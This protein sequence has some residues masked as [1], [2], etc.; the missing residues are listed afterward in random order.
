M[1]SLL[2]LFVALLAAQSAQSAEEPSFLLQKFGSIDGLL[3]DERDSRDVVRCPAGLDFA[4]DRLT[5]RDGIGFQ[6]VWDSLLEWRVYTL[7]SGTKCFVL[8]KPKLQILDPTD[9][10]L[11]YAVRRAYLVPPDPHLDTRFQAPTLSRPMER[12]QSPE[13]RA[14]RFPKAERSPKTIIDIRQDDRE[15]VSP[16]VARNALAYIYIPGST[17]TSPGLSAGTGTQITPYAWLTNAHVIRPGNAFQTSALLYATY[18]QTLPLFVSSKVPVH[19]MSVARDYAGTPSWHDI[20]AV[21][22]TEPY[23]RERYLAILDSFE[24]PS[25]SSLGALVG[26]PAHVRNQPNSP[27]RP[28]TDLAN[29]YRRA[30]PEFLPNGPYRY[31]F[32]RGK[33]SQGQSGGPAH[34]DSGAEDKLW[35]LVTSS[36]DGLIPASAQD[37]FLTEIVYVTPLQYQN[38]AFVRAVLE[39]HPPVSILT[40]GLYNGVALDFN[41]FD[42]FRA[43]AGNGTK[44]LVWSSSLDGVFGQGGYV[45]SAGT[46]RTGIHE[47]TIA[48]DA[49]PGRL[50]ATSD[51]T[52]GIGN[53]RRLRVEVLG[54][55]GE[56]RQS[57]GSGEYAVD[58]RNNLASVG[59]TWTSQNG[60]ASAVVLNEITGMHVGSGPQGFASTTAAPGTHKFGFF[61]DQTRIVLI[62]RESMSVFV[63][64][65]TLSA[66]PSVCEIVPTRLNPGPSSCDTVI[67]WT[68]GQF[69][70]GAPQAPDATVY[71]RRGPAGAWAESF[72]APSS[73][74]SSRAIELG[75]T[76]FALKQFRDP[77][78]GNLA[79]PIVAKAVRFADAREYNNEPLYAPALA[80]VDGALQESLNFSAPGDIDWLEVY[81][82]QAGR[83]YRFATS[84]DA[85]VR[86]ELAVYGYIDTVEDQ[87]GQ[88]P[89][90]VRNVYLIGSS[91]AAANGSPLSIDVTVPSS[92]SYAGFVVR[93]ANQNGA[94]CARA[95]AQ[96]TTCSGFGYL[97]SAYDLTAAAQADSYEPDGTR[98]SARPIDGGGASQTHTFHTASDEDWVMFWLPAGYRATVDLRPNNTA[99]GDHWNAEFWSVVPGTSNLAHLTTRSFGGAGTQLVGDALGG[100]MFWIRVRSPAG[101]VQGLDSRYVV[102]VAAELVAQQDAYEPDDTRETAVSNGPSSTTHNFHTS[103]D[104][105]WTSMWIGAGWRARIAVAPT[106][107]G[108]TSGWRAEVWTVD[109]ATYGLMLDQQVE[110]G[111]SGAVLELDGLSGRSA[112]LRVLSNDGVNVGNGSTYTV[113]ITI[114]A[115]PATVPDVFEQDDT[116]ETFH[117]MQP[118]DGVQ[119]HSFH[120]SGDEDWAGAW[121]PSGV[122]MTARA[123]SENPLAA[124]NWVLDVYSVD[125]ATYGLL[126]M[127]SQEFG[128]AGEQF[129]V[130][131]LSGRMVWTR[132][133]SKYAGAIGPKTAYGIQYSIP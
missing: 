106:M 34:E 55:S 115:S 29:Y 57:S 70:S 48:L 42:A 122:T 40:P 69:S 107:T 8:Q 14:K 6:W 65:G 114:V 5:H 86:S 35:G 45:A 58:L 101:T 23:V 78:S 44:N 129:T 98:E 75:D 49:A 63:P 52:V 81:T 113:G 76:E 90:D 95:S 119:W 121:V 127:G 28:Y 112:W 41:S 21:F 36:V 9:V 74:G 100:R 59:L 72:H 66:V 60:P 93:V 97:L 130:P 68:Q 54:P 82:L 125:L 105:D 16:F 10:E 116:R 94:G 3:L 25:A 30:H 124:R 7:G 118:S 73:L 24:D 85:G 22:T 62:D 46:L 91:V 43:E 13:D 80:L 53:A 83:T 110:F 17:P 67:S 19:S 71:S 15:V 26:Y 27:V 120:V 39:W 123:F 33:I 31:E 38:A 32:S 77:T 92:H 84:S 61:K 89:V 102:S 108:R 99:A 132:V 64:T 133:R 104:N 131:G 18:D 2:V 96:V 1:K 51:P 50:E 88:E 117:A 87:G 20:G 12:W 4:R 56:L 11:L 111:S 103:A 126:F 37:Q 109:L 128:P 47:I 79:P